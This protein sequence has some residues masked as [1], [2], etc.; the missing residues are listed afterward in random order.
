MI[1]VKKNQKYVSDAGTL[2]RVVTKGYYMASITNIDKRGRAV[3]NTF[4]TV[5]VDSI[6]RRYKLV[7]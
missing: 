2:V 4:R 1:N 7:A 5:Q 3:K 6:R